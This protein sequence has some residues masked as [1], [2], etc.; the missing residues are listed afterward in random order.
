MS[1]QCLVH[2]GMPK[3]GSSALQT[4]LANEPEFAGA[5]GKR[6]S[7]VAIHPKGHLL[8]GG[9][10]LRRQARRNASGYVISAPPKRLGELSSAHFDRLK[11]Q[12]AEVAAEGVTPI[13]SCEGWGHLHDVFVR[14]GYFKKMD[15]DCR[16]ICYVR[17]QVAWLNS[18]WWQFGAWQAKPLR[19]WID[20]RME[21]VRWHNVLNGW[22]SVPGVSSVEV[23][24]LPAS[25]V[26][27]FLGL[28]GAT[29]PR[30]VSSNV[31]LPGAVL[32]LFQRHRELRPLPQD[33]AIEFVISRHIDLGKTRTPWVLDRD[34]VTEII[35]KCEESNRSLLERLEPDQRRRMEE[36][37]AW[38][39]PDHY[40]GRPVEPAG[41]LPPDA[42]AVDA[43]AAAALKALFELDESYRS[44]LADRSRERE[45]PAPMPVQDER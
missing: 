34:L 25:I 13:L 21:I 30:E 24:L 18:A 37:P 26:G 6:Y 45:T 1:T 38:W 23:R 10:A 33:A 17:P 35:G 3:C 32:R 27:D 20:D 44:L 22:Q 36:D 15:L 16:V 8:S 5:D 31:G 41:V 39:S 28:L 11:T 7:Y 12:F 14:E 4:A 29:C 43:L 9:G 19:S 40:D 2:V 42:A